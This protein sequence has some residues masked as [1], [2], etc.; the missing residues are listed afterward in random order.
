MKVSREGTHICGIS[1][2]TVFANRIQIPRLPML[3]PNIGR[4]SKRSQNFIILFLTRMCLWMWQK[5]RWLGDRGRLRRI[6][7]PRRKSGVSPS[8]WKRINSC[9]NWKPFST[10]SPFVTPLNWRQSAVE[11]KLRAV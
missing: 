10:S 6:R 9:T 1:R 5:S 4:V 7:N 3:I 2:T 11:R 8:P